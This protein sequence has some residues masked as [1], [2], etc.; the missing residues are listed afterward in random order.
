MECPCR[1]C[2]KRFPGCHSKCKDY[3][4]WKK[5]WKEAEQRRKD[6]NYK[7]NLYYTG[8]PKRR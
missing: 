8:I 2:K 4:S 6:Q 7:D 5:W 1:W 3:K